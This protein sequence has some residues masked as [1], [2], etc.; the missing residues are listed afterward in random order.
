MN[1][2]IHLKNMILSIDYKLETSDHDYN[3]CSDDECE[4]DCNILNY[5]KEIDNK[6]IKKNNYE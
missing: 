3:Q 1:M 5:K 2:R 4:Y 6:L